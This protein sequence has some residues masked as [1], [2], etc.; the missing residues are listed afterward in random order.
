VSLGQAVYDDQVKPYLKSSSPGKR[1][2]IKEFPL[3]DLL[4]YNGMDALL[5][6]KLAQRQMRQMGVVL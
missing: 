6:Y 2:R 3:K 4:L 1:N 5:E